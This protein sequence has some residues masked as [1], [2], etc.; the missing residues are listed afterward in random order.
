VR[1]ATGAQAM[2]ANVRRELQAVDPQVPASTVKTMEQFL[3]A[4][5]ASRRFNMLLLTAFAGAALVLS[6]SGL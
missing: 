5:I 6:M 3:A 1:S 4:S 2:V